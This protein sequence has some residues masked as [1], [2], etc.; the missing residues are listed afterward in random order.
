MEVRMVARC[1]RVQ[2]FDIQASVE[3]DCEKFPMLGYCS[4]KGE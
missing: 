1:V 3:L 2:S 4:K